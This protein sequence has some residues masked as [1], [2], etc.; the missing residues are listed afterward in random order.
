MIESVLRGSRFAK[1]GLSRLRNLVR[2]GVYAVVT[3]PPVPPSYSQA[4]EDAVIRFLFADRR[5]QRISYLDVGT[6]RPISGNN[7]YLF[8][9]NGCRGVCVEA[10]KTLIPTIVKA[11][12]HDKVINAGVADGDEGEADFYIID[13]MGLN[14][15]DK[16]EADRVVALSGHKVVETVKVPLVSINRLIAENFEHRPDLLSIDI[17]GWDLRVLKTLDFERFPIPVICAETCVY[18]DNHIRSKNTGIAEFLS[19]K[20]YQVYADTYINT[21]FVN[22]DWFYRV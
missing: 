4:G 1:Q 21:V 11:R 16:E 9:R 3:P 14:T 6:N 5:I 18:S 17:E 12:P 15:F 8:Y 20:G 13:F 7:T 10:D 19:T 2:K 22:K